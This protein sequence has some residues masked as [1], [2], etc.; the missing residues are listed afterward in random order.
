MLADIIYLNSIIATELVRI[1][2]NTAAIRRG[3]D[4]LSQSPCVPEH[5]ALNLQV[6]DIVRKYINKPEDCDKKECLENHVLKH[7]EESK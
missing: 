2:E 4:F 6:I 7:L 3:E 1:T 5:D